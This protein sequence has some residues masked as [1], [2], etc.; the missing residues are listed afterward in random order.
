[1][2]SNVILSTSHNMKKYQQENL[3]KPPTQNSKLGDSWEV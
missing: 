2:F 3:W 1:M